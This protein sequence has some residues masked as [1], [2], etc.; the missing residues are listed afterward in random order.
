M[1]DLNNK[2]AGLKD[3]V[4][5]I[6]NE[7]KS[8]EENESKNFEQ[9]TINAVTN[10]I[11]LP[12]NYSKEIPINKLNRALLRNYF[13]FPSKEQNQFSNTINNTNT[14]RNNKNI[15][16][17][18]NSYRTIMSPQNLGKNIHMNRISKK[19]SKM[20][21]RKIIDNNG[22]NNNESKIK[23]LGSNDLNN[24][25]K[26]LTIDIEDNS[27]INK[28]VLKHIKSK[29]KEC[30]RQKSGLNENK[31]DEIDKIIMTYSNNGNLKK[32]IINDYFSYSKNKNGFNKKDMLYNEYNNFNTHNGKNNK[33][34]SK[35]AHLSVQ[36]TST[37][38]NIDIKDMINLNN[39]NEKQN[40]NGS[41][42]QFN[43]SKLSTK[44]NSKKNTNKNNSFND[45]LKV[46]PNCTKINNIK[47]SSKDNK[48][49]SRNDTN[50]NSSRNTFILNNEFFLYD[51]KELLDKH[52]N[53]NETYQNFNFGLRPTNFIPMN[54]TINYLSND[55]SEDFDLNNK[56]KVINK[57]KIR[58][59][60]GKSSIGDIYL[61]AK[62]FEKC[63]ENNFGNYVHE[64][65]DTN[66]SI[67]NLKKYKKFIAQ[68]KEEE[69]QDKK[70]I[71][72]YQRLCKKI[73]ELLNPQEINEIVGEIQNN[74]VE[75]END[76]YIIEEIK[77]ILPY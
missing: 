43:G 66:N 24:M 76:N 7:I 25:N 74:F 12:S 15:K 20:I 61:K 33:N 19:F 13:K 41:L 44:N 47:K 57:K 1:E 56:E 77:S 6:K 14:F 40:F 67:N 63:G 51:D 26:Y 30:T 72:V 4:K 52:K 75:N 2:L 32:N 54:N 62:L 5:K 16:N 34:I 28:N 11:F 8:F 10:K 73:I 55:S 9:R 64:Y 3:T 53:F 17:N 49:F 68:L 71:N 37:N 29:Q 46:I 48:N 42:F 39:D 59:I 60:L 45:K 69:I 23:Y 18:K 70:L 36:R 50:P 27:C 35:S 65:C 38:R 31:I 22:G 58:K 21:N